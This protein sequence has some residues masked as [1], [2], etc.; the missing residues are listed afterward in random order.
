MQIARYQKNETNECGA[1]ANDE[2]GN[3]SLLAGDI[4]VDEHEPNPCDPK[5]H[6][7]RDEQRYYFRMRLHRLVSLSELDVLVRQTVEIRRVC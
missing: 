6:P 1:S 3:Q 2:N 4:L 7:R 5:H